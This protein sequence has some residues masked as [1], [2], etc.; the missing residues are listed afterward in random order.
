VKALI[1]LVVTFC[2]LAVAAI[3]AASTPRFEGWG[4]Y[5]VAAAVVVRIA[6]A[7]RNTPPSRHGGV[8]C[9]PYCSLDDGLAPYCSLDGRNAAA[10]ASVPGKEKAPTEGC[11][12]GALRWRVDR[13]A[14]PLILFRRQ[15]PD[16]A[17]FWAEPTQL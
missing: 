6:I 14:Y 17:I 1:T 4:V 15:S 16:K 8:P 11:L 9:G 5:L 12:V 2:L 3:V 7:G 13:E 10:R